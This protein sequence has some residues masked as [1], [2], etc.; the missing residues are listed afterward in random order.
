M[1][2]DLLKDIRT[3]FGS[4]VSRSQSLGEY[5]VGKLGFSVK[6]KEI[7]YS[8][9]EDRK[10]KT[11]KVYS[12]RFNVYSKDGLD[13]SLRETRW[14]HQENHQDRFVLMD[15]V[16]GSGRHYLNLDD[17][18]GWIERVG[19]RDVAW[20]FDFPFIAVGASP[21]CHVNLGRTRMG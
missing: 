17:I 3:K 13:L 20:S 21:P 2:K 15:V 4:M 6:E 18:D 14:L 7:I 10:T 9:A 12:E 5:L 1:L 11:R 8:V 19:D 16:E